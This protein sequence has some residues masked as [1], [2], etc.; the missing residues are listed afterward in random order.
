MHCI[1]RTRL[2]RFVPATSSQKAA[3]ARCFAVVPTL[4][5]LAAIAIFAALAGCHSQT[6]SESAPQAA[7]QSQSDSPSGSQPQPAPAQ[8]N[9]AS[10]AAQSN[11]APS[12]PA[13]DALQTINEPGGAQVVY[14]TID[15]QHTPQSAMAFMLKQ[16]H[17]HYADKPAVSNIFQIKGTT[18]YAA[19]F[20][21]I[22]KNAGNTPIAGEVI[23]DLPKGGQPIAAVLTDNAAT[24]THSQP[25][26]LAALDKAWHTANAAPAAT[27]TPAAAPASSGSVP[28][29]H[30]VTGGDRSVYISIPDGWKVD[31]IAGGSVQAEGPKGERVGLALMIQGIVNSRMPIPGRIAYPFGGDVFTAYTNIVSQSRANQHLPA[32]TFHLNSSKP[33][34]GGAVQVAFDVDLHDGFGERTA[35]ARLQEI[36]GAGGTW[37]LGFSNSSL[38]KTIATAENATLMAVIQSASQDPNVVKAEQGAVMAGIAAAGARSKAEAQAADARREASAQAFDAHMDDIDRQ[39]KA[40][41]NYTL[42]RSQIQDNDANG[43][44]TVSNGLADALVKSD[45]TRYQVVP[46]SQF[47][48]GADY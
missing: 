32:A 1:A 29:L 48:K 13:P 25:V 27:T 46:P 47:L 14:G 26:M 36:G 24:F 18:S 11:A 22:A 42:D 38:P 21:L 9:S 17:G 35:T 44:A 28:P 43:R 33:L 7:P 34:G 6:P 16:V 37:A 41:Q 4:T 8:S 12:N 2:I 20:T 5:A 10:N 31:S 45:P 40:M 15:D 3:P 39:S 23:V 19:F 30:R